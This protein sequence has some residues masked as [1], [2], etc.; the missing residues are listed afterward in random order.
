MFTV[1]PAANQPKLKLQPTCSSYNNNTEQCWNNLLMNGLKRQW[2][3]FLSFWKTKM[4]KSRQGNWDNLEERSVLALPPADTCSLL[5]H[6][7]NKMATQCCSLRMY[8]YQLIHLTVY[9][10]YL[11]ETSNLFLKA[12][13]HC[14]LNQ[15]RLLIASR[16]TSLYI[17]ELRVRVVA[18]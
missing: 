16:N 4:G 11:Q 12:L 18:I 15:R 14:C 3:V 17:K 6:I 8:K 13:P 7:Y 5:Y 2:E 9:L 1:N 10:L